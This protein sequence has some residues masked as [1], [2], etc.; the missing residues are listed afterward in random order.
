MNYLDIIILAILGWS[1]FRG[2]KNGLFIEI[3]SV[4]ALILGIWGSIRFSGFT[5]TK[6][7]EYFDLQ[8]QYLGLIAFI[9]TFI[10]IVVLIHF[11]ANALD[12]LLKAVALGIF[13]RL[14]GMVFAVIKSVLILSVVF[15]VLSTF[16]RSSK[17]ITTEQKEESVLYGTVADFAPMLFPIIE[18]GDLRDSFDRLRSRKAQRAGTEEPGVIV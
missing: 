12:K 9:I 13:V 11:L 17:L 6:L 10:V 1:L 7:V 4:A 5:Q 16:D 15:M 8:T 2:F 14:L 3:A 18:G